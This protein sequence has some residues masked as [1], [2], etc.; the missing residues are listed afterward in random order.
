[1]GIQR[2]ALVAWIGV[3]IV[4]CATPAVEDP[5]AGKRLAPP[6]ADHVAILTH[7]DRPAADLAEDAVRNPS[8]VLAFTGID[9]GMTV[10]ELEAGGG[11]YTE[12]FAHT[13]GPVGKVFMHNPLVFDVFFGDEIVARLDDRLGNVQAIRTN[14]DEITVAD[15]SA[16]LVTWFLGPHT[17]W[18]R[19]ENAPPEAFGNPDK[20]FAEIVRVLKPGGVFVAIDHK[21]MPGAPAAS[22]SDTDRIDPAIV[23]EHAKRAGLELVEESDLFAN[24]DDDYSVSAFDPSVYGKTDRFV[25]KFRKAR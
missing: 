24:A 14:F 16:D 21:A 20:A 10:V 7:P 9:Y 12:L 6:P 3:A 4:A 22:G 13:V 15:G 5:L 1:M 17:L 18:F 23:L 19:P 8:E 2:L 11:Y 25:F